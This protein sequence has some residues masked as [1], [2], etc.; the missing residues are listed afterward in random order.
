MDENIIINYD[1]LRVGDEILVTSGGRFRYYRI[2]REPR[3]NSL[4]KWSGVRVS[5]NMHTSEVTL[6][7][8]TPYE[9]GK[10]SMMYM[11]ALTDIIM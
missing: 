11:N 2:L 5:T 8:G 9:R 3:K 10:E 6:Y 1:E 4:G 7:S